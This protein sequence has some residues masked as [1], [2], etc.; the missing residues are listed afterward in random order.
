MYTFNST[1]LI[2]QQ[3]QQQQYQMDN[4]DFSQIESELTA[5]ISKND[6]FTSCAPYFPV[7]YYDMWSSAS[8][9]KPQ[10]INT[11]VVSGPLEPHG[12]NTSSPTSSG[13]HVRAIIKKSSNT[14]IATKTEISKSFL[15]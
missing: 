5:I 4:F 11:N 3:Q 10:F 15:N 14:I 8:C 13:D 2:Q 6:S 1:S 7:N 9:F 12:P